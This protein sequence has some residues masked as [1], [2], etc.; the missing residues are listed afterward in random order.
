MGVSK[1]NGTPKS[2]ILIGFFHYKP[3]ILGYPY[4]WKHPYI[5]TT[6]PIHNAQ[7]RY[8]IDH[9]MAAPTIFGSSDSKA[10]GISGDLASASLSQAEIWDP[11]KRRD[12][13]PLFFLAKRMVKH[14][15]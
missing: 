6:N 7:G 15:K 4:F 5:A 1:N 9:L 11:P 2:S 14:D 8:C 12:T 3:S 10:Q 13:V